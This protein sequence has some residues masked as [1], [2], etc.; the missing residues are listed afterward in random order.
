MA[1]QASPRVNPAPSDY[2]RSIFVDKCE[3]HV[4]AGS[5]GNGCVAFHRDMH[6]SDG[7]PNGGDGGSGGNIWI[8][9]VAGHTSLHKLARRG[10]IKAGRGIGGQGKNQGGSKG[11]D[12]LIQVPVGTVIRERWRS[13]P[14]AD[15]E[16]RLKLVGGE[17]GLDSEEGSKSAFRR[18]RWVLYPGVTPSESAALALPTPPRPRR[19]SLA[20]MQPTAPIL[21]D[22]SEP[23]E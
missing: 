23:M 8:Q 2:A 17:M 21:L 14:T 10:I 4:H 3:L 5:G 13:D 22:L 20:P 9:A 6:I 11:A 7:P 16:E 18:D 12:A 15:E 1:G 19:S